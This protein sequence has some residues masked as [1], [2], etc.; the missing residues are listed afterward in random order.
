MRVSAGFL[1]MGLSGKIRIQIRPLRLMNRVMAIRAASI[2]LLPNHP[3]S[4]AWSPKSPKLRVLPREAL[5]LIFP[6]CCFRY[7]VFAGINMTYSL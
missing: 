7:F 6:F 3:H 1:V 5:P 2:S 4:M